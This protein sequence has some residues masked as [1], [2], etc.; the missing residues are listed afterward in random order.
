M[1]KKYIKYKDTFTKNMNAFRNVKVNIV[2]MCTFYKNKLIKIKLY[3]IF[4]LLIYFILHYIFYIS[5][6][7]CITPYVNFILYTFNLFIFLTI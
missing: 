6:I 2:T 7:I 3:Y 1:L 4:I 5:F